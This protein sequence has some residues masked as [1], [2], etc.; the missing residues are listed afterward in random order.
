MAFIASGMNSLQLKDGTILFP[1]YG[2]KQ[3]ND[4]DSSQVLRS[5]DYGETWTLVPVATHPDGKTHLNEPEIVEVKDGKLLMVMRTGVG[6]DHLWQAMSEDGGATWK[7]VRDTGVQGHPPDLL[8]LQDG[9]LLLS[10]G[11]R[12]TPFGV[13]AAVSADEGQTWDPKQIWTLRDDGGGTDLGYPHSAQLKDGTV[14]T[15]YYFF[16][17]GGM[18][19]VACTRW[20][21]PPGPAK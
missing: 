17:P 20:Q 3:P 10:Y 15:V 5:T 21:V 19:Y 13:R 16:E 4:P 14:V 9:R 11:Y 6:S 7:D 1:T 8:R 12:H 18:Q 2:S